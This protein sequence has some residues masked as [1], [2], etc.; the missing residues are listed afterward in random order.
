M[1]GYDTVGK[2]L[3]QNVS[4]RCD[5]FAHLSGFCQDGKAI[6]GNTKDEIIGKGFLQHSCTAGQELAARISSLLANPDAFDPTPLPWLV[7]LS[8]QASERMTQAA[9][10]NE[11]KRSI[12]KKMRLM[13][14]IAVPW[15]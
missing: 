15:R 12:L 14:G 9:F 6:V 11:L 7:A 8:N 3:A 5:A 13:G 10:V 1:K 2:I 4:R